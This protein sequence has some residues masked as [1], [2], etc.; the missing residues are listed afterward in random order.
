MLLAKPASK[1]VQ[2][3]APPAP[4]LHVQQQPALHRHARLLRVQPPVALL[5]P[6]QHRHVLL[7]HVQHLHV[8]PLRA[9]PALAVPLLLAVQ[10]GAAALHKPRFTACA[11][12]A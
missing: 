6:A 1:P 3:V 4:L 7:Q 12:A 5:L 8:Q 2:N 11:P 9:Q 10:Q